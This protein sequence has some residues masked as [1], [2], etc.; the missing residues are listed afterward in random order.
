MVP[1][2]T[3]FEEALPNSIAAATILNEDP[4]PTNIPVA[5]PPFEIGFSPMYNIATGQSAVT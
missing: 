1:N 3:G 2:V 4:S 5:I